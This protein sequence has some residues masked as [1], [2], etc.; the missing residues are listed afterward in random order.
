MIGDHP[1]MTIHEWPGERKAK[2]GET[3]LVAGHAYA[4]MTVKEV[5]SK[6]VKLLQLRNPWGE[7]GMEW[8]GDWS[9]NSPLWT[10]AI[11]AEIGIDGE[12]MDANDGAFWMCLE[13]FAK[14]FYSV[15]A[16]MCRHPD[17]GSP[18]WF[19][20]R[21]KMTFTMSDNEV[22]APCYLLTLSEASDKVFFSIHQQDIRNVKAKPYVDF[23][24]TVLQ[25]NASTGKYTL[26]ASSGN[27][28]DRQLQTKEISLPAGQY[29]VLPTSTGCVLRTL[30]EKKLNACVVVHTTRPHGLVEQVGDTR[31]G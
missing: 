13:D 23:G 15:N 3:G 24:V 6:G 17:L 25:L 27:S 9:D 19:E 4:L 5:K 11:K 22:H 1:W 18:K 8:N 14:Y 31:L 12:V 26:I 30:A 10:T 21:K 29:L 2:D 28:A 16:C 7:G 20:S